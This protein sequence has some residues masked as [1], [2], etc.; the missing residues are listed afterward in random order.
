MGFVL[1]GK[2]LGKRSYV[3]KKTGEV[4]YTVDVYDG[5]KVVNVGQVEE[6]VYQSLSDGDEVSFE[7]RVSAYADN[8]RGRLIVSYLNL[9]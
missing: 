4:V 3:S 6:T 5:S 7:V 9:V 1:R 2:F 8:G